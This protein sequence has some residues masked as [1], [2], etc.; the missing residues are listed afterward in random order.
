VRIHEL[1]SEGADKDAMNVHGDLLKKSSL[2]LK[3]IQRDCFVTVESQDFIF[4]AMSSNS[5]RSEKV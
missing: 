2:S 3:A 1:R 4:A 5:R